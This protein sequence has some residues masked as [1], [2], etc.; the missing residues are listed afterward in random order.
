MYVH[1]NL[2]TKLLIEEKKNTIKLR[3]LEI[4]QKIGNH[5]LGKRQKKLNYRTE[6]MKIN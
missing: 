6:K 4:L 1:D 3:S 2:N 5:L